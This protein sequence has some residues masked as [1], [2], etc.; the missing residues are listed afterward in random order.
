MVDIL[1][2]RRVIGFELGCWLQ[3]ILVWGGGGIVRPIS[4]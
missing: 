2:G 4:I 3:H 1:F